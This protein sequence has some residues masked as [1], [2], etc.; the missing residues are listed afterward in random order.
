MGQR[1]QCPYR[2]AL[3]GRLGGR[4]AARR[5]RAPRLRARR[6]HGVQQSCG[7]LAEADRGQGP[8]RLRRSRRSRRRWLRREP[9]ASRRQYHRLRRH[10]WPD[11]RQVA[12]GAQGDRAPRQARHDAHASRDAHPAG[13]LAFVRGGGAGLW[14]RAD[15]GRR[16]RRGRDRAC[17]R[18]LR[19]QGKQRRH[20]QPA[21][22][23][24]GQRGADRRPDLAA[25]SAH[26]LRHC[27]IR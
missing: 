23:H 24:L 22:H 13:V 25:S 8:D 7:R 17:D 19:N 21:C 15:A 5:R 9:R 4:D 20:R 2:D 1:P 26:A 3:V 16:P 6:D 11:R 27:C 12:G 14:R 10:R 18:V